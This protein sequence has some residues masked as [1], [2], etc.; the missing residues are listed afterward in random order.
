MMQD[1]V[2]GEGIDDPEL[3]QERKA[4]AAAIYIASLSER[5]KIRIY[6]G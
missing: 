2:Y 5:V 1:A 4:P 3:G 6:P